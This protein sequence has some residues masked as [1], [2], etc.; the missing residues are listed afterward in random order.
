MIKEKNNNQKDKLLILGKHMSAR[1]KH[2]G[3]NKLDKPPIL[4]GI[5]KKKII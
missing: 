4:K 5:T 2:K 1:W 3:I